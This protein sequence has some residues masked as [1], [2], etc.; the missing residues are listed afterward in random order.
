MGTAKAA[1][2][3]FKKFVVE[4]YGSKPVIIY[5]ESPVVVDNLTGEV[6]KDK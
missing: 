3:S 6:V 2:D 1:L 5:F 4:R